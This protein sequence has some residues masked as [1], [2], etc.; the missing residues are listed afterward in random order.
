MKTFNVQSAHRDGKTTEMFRKIVLRAIENNYTGI[1]IDIVDYGLVNELKT[2]IKKLESKLSVA[3]E[4]L[5][6]I[7]NESRPGQSSKKHWEMV[8]HSACAE[9]L[10]K[11]TSVARESLAKIKAIEN[12][13]G[14]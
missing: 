2:K 9:V 11:D 10:A 6:S 4:A 12:G 14:E 7:A 8:S 13:E 1:S 5:E 3:V